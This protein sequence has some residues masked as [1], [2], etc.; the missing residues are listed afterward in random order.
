MM[1]WYKF[2]PVDTLFFKGAEPMVM[3]EN[4]T[5]SHLFP[6]MPQTIAGALRTAVLVQKQIDFSDYARGEVSADILEAVGMAGSPAPF[7]VTGP[8]FMAG[9]EIFAPAPYHWFTEKETMEKNSH[10]Q[11]VMVYKGKPVTTSLLK[12]PFSPVYWATGDQGELVSLGG[13][14]IR[15]HDLLAGNEMVELKQAADLFTLEERTGIALHQNRKVREG[16]LYTFNH[17]RLRNNVS[18]IF[19]ADQDLPLADSG[20]LKLGGE[21]RFGQYCKFSPSVDWP[22]DDN[23][24]FVSLSAIEGSEEAEATLIATGK[25]LYIG[26]WD[27]HKGF[28]KHMKGYFPPGTV[29]NKKINAN[30]ITIQGV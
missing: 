17:I 29:F 21:Q 4:H 30:L 22:S 11:P 25:I 19:G 8:L 16:H 3:G 18:M 20:V 12:T 13:T 10:P 28:H 2:D 27:M 6:P 23:G 7:S 15:L 14:W 5:T 24:L 26:G 9:E 1:N